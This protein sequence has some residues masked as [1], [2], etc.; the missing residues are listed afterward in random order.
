VPA[1]E[2]AA[3]R[4]RRGLDHERPVVALG[5]GA[6][7][8][9]KRWPEAAFGAVARRLTSEGFA[10]WVLGSPEEHPLAEAII[11]GAGPHARNLTGPDLRDAVLALRSA[12]VA[13]CNDSGLLHVAAAIGTPTIGIF[14]PTSPR[15]WAPLNPLAAVVE[16]R[17]PVPCRPCHKP[18]CRFGHHRCMREIP[19]Q[20]VL[21]AVH[22][23]LSDA[24]ITDS[25]G[26]LRP[27]NRGSSP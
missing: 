25:D 16:T 11:A 15:L 22:R 4:A 17:T 26:V 8:P 1:E 27:L 9:S 14:G 13:I 20:D 24:R 7:N 18:R 6:M 5:P 2:A 3:W 10:V 21:A 23:A 12:Q 19:A